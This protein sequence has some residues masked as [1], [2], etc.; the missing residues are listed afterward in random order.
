VR[1]FLILGLLNK[2]GGR[3]RSG[4][5]P[6]YQPRRGPNARPALP[7][8]PTPP[9]RDPRT[10]PVM[11][12]R[13]ELPDRVNAPAKRRRRFYPGTPCMFP[14]PEMVA[15]GRRCR[16]DRSSTFTMESA[17]S[18]NYLFRVFAPR[19]RTPLARRTPTDPAKLIVTT[20]HHPASYFPA[21]N[22][23]MSLSNMSLARPHRSLW[24]RTDLTRCCS[25]RWTALIA[26]R[27]VPV[28]I[29]IIHRQT[30]AAMPQGS[31][32]GSGVRHDVRPSMRR[33]VEKRSAATCGEAIQT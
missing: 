9:T 1:H 33:F 5:C 8:R 15:P 13:K 7:A 16:R 24:G 25:R 4:N 18:T 11:W 30:A 32:R 20:S 27:R 2:Y 23:G 28:M 22:R 14:A 31:E 10:L 3:R 19:T 21:S 6:S 17:D 26:Q 29:A 12:R